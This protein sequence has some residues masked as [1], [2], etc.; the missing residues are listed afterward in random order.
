MNS[1][2]SGFPT[3]AYS[4]KGHRLPDAPWRVVVSAEEVEST[5]VHSVRLHLNE[6]Y[7]LVQE[8]I[9]G[10][11]K[12]IVE[13][14]LTASIARTLIATVSRLS[15]DIGIPATLDSVAGDFPDSVAAAARNVAR[16]YLNRTLDAAV[17]DYRNRP[18]EFEYKLAGAV[19]LMRVK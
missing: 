12:P 18:E 7:P 19:G 4:F 8:L 16:V 1:E 13:Q 17:S 15:A 11:P 9:E 10:R 5:F 2:A 6:D 14:E 3:S